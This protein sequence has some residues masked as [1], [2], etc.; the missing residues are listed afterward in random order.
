MERKGLS[1]KLKYVIRG[2]P[3]LAAVAASLLPLSKIS[4]QLV[5]LIV[6]LWIQVFFIFDC[7]HVNK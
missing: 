1:G 5:I 2:M 3:L 7:F 4:Q 6:L